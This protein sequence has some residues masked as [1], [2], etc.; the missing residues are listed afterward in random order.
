M[1]IPTNISEI[2]DLFELIIRESYPTLGAIIAISVYSVFVFIFYRALAKRDLITLNL[3][4]YSDNLSGRLKKYSRIIFFVLQYIIFVPVLI[5]FWLSLIH[6]SEPT[7]P[8]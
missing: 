7:R 6:I 3:N 2:E 8:Y 5:T 1:Q 4:H